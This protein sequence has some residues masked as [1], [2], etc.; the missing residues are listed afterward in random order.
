MR[1]PTRTNLFQQMVAAVVSSLA[2]DDT[3]VTEPKM[4]VGRLSG[5][6]REVDVCVEG[7]LA[8]QSV[9]V[10]IECRDHARPQTVAWVDE[11]QGKHAEL[12]IHATVL[13][14]A[15]GFTK[16]ARKKAESLGIATARPGPPTGRFFADLAGRSHFTMWRAELTHLGLGF[17]LDSPGGGVERAFV[18]PDSSVPVLLGDGAMLCDSEE[19]ASEFL[20][21]TVISDDSMRSAPQGE[22]IKTLVDFAPMPKA[23]VSGRSVDTY[24]V[25]D[26][27]SGTALRIQS[28]VLMLQV[29]LHSGVIPLSF[30]ELQGVGC[31]FGTGIVGGDT[32]N[33]VLTET[34][35]GQ[36]FKSRRVERISSGR[37]K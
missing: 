28:V 22:V 17:T 10:G 31:A 29:E 32:V 5:E 20:A 13:A 36:R 14:S 35:T 21:R 1:V 2:S 3:T 37:T 11:V 26:A 19:L 9:V 7:V 23:I 30:C 8:G 24:L 16:G 4:L 27:E 15:S 6:N 34:P 18:G 12:P 33:V 25:M